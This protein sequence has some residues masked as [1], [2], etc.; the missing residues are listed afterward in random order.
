MSATA[1]ASDSGAGPRPGRVLR[2]AP[3]MT[4]DGER[5]IGPSNVIARSSCAISAPIQRQRGRRVS[6]AQRKPRRVQPCHSG[7]T[8]DQDGGTRI[9]IGVQSKHRTPNFCYSSLGVAIAERA[10]FR[11][12]ARQAVFRA[13]QMSANARPTPNRRLVRPSAR[14][15]GSRPRIAPPRSDAP[16]PWRPRQADRR[17]DDRA[18]DH[19]H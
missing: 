4:T 12:A 2:R 7:L 19:E 3:E 17:T 8:P 1:L 6:A 10:G 18:I 5:W 13:G 14:G 11:P 16:C 9:R 15:P